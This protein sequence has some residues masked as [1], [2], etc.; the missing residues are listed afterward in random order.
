MFDAREGVL[1]AAK[2]ESLAKFLRLLIGLGDEGREEVAKILRARLVAVLERL[3]GIQV[4]HVAGRR[5][6]GAEAEVGMALLGAP[7]DGLGAQRAGNPHLRM[8]LLIR[9]CPRIYMPVVKMFAL[10]APRSRPGPRL[11][12]EVVRFLEVFAVVGG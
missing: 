1:A 4:P 11:N 7:S 2:E 3:V 9:Q 10:I 6:R 8:R 12:D 5:Q